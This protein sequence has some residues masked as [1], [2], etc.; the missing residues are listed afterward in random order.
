MGSNFATKHSQRNQKTKRLTKM[1]LISLFTA[2]VAA[3]T[4][5]LPLLMMDGADDDMMM[6]MMGNSMGVNQ[7]DSFSQL[8][9]LMLMGSDDDSDDNSD[10]LMMMMMM[11]PG[12]L[13]DNNAMLPLMFLMTTMMQKDCTHDT[14]DQMSSMLPLLLMGEN[15]ND[16]KLKTLLMFQMM[17]DGSGLNMDSMLPMLMLGDD[18]DEM[19]E[20]L[21]MVLMSSLGSGRQEASTYDSGF[22][23]MLPLMM[24][25]DDADSDMM[26][27]MM[28]MQAQSPSTGST[29]D[30][31]L[32]MMLMKD[33][34]DNSSLLVFMMMSQGQQCLPVVPD[35][36]SPIINTP[37][38]F[39][40]VPATTE[41][42]DQVIYRTW[43][44]NADGTRTL[45]STDEHGSEVMHIADKEDDANAN[46]TEEEIPTDA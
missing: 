9:P 38:P 18:D 26:M 14:N 13:G 4:N 41:E 17:S 28:M 31:M 36:V 25:G 22:N 3:N 15:G 7:Q 46:D 37:A 27:L 8:L 30:S 42:P 20:V 45:I 35:Y 44:L 1:K 23:L 12:M 39:V 33:D 29:M 21:M 19:S 24:A 43:R 6:L 11:N 5:M 10:M 2:S 32:P 40:P 16:D 34:S